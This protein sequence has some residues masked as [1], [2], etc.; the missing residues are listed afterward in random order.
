MISSWN[1]AK[2][3]RAKKGENKKQGQNKNARIT[4]FPA[5]L[6]IKLTVKLP[7]MTLKNSRKW[8][9]IHVLECSYKKW[10]LSDTKQKLCLTD[11]VSLFFG[12]SRMSDNQNMNCQ[13]KRNTQETRFWY[14][15]VPLR[16]A[17]CSLSHSSDCVLAMFSVF[18]QLSYINCSYPNLQFL[19]HKP[20]TFMFHLCFWIPQFQHFDTCALFLPWSNQKKP[21][22]SVVPRCEL[23][24]FWF[25]FH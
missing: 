1:R 3:D 25:E 19:W 13:N 16:S 23:K 4:V 18:T 21:L 10:L 6:K 7:K 12:V 5:V 9:K 22:F 24:Q 8:K 2:Q 14:C 11:P 17:L 20:S 15:A